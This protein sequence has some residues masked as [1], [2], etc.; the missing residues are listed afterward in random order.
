MA[1]A[2]FKEPSI[3]LEQVYRE[4]TMAI[5]QKRYQRVKQILEYAIGRLDP[6]NPQDR[7]IRAR[8]WGSLS[9]A[10]LALGDEAA[11]KQIIEKTKADPWQAYLD[12]YVKAYWERYAGV[13]ACRSGGKECRR[14]SR[15]SRKAESSLTSL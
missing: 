9:I 6:S 2:F 13:V 15:S 12:P 5:Q 10:L 8:L 3:A 1:Q 4:V 14:S 7:I 11:A